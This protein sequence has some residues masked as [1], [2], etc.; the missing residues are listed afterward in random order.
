MNL[1]YAIPG[2]GTTKD[3]FQYIKI[4]NTE[5]VVLEWPLLDKNETMS[6]LANKMLTQIDPAK[7]F[8]LLGVSLGGMVSIEISSI[9]KP[10][11][12]ILISSAR[13]R[14]ELPLLLRCLKYIPLNKFVTESQYRR[15]AKNSRR[16]L[17]FK[18]EYREQFK[19]MVESMKPY[20]FSRAIQCLIS[21]KRR[22]CL[23]A[24]VIK[25]HGDADKLL[26]FR[27]ADT[28]HCV[29]NGSHAMIVDRAAEINSILDKIINSK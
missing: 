8:Y 16:V 11:K 2:L 9:K 23:S 17:G 22:E 24:D 1:V 26:K 7:P 5:L 29:K 27:K 21:W 3:L 12:T 6:S 25:I 19:T 20:H 13:C 4:E 10:V 28:D 14:K 18:R 15:I